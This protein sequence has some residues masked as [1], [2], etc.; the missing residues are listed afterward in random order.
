MSELLNNLQSMTSVKNLALL[1]HISRSF[2]MLI[3]IEHVFF[4]YKITLSLCI[5]SNYD[6]QSN[7]IVDFI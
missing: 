3:P 5:F 2:A 7:L 6:V 1:F 4:L